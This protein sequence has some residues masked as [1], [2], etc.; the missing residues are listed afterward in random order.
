MRSAG[1]PYCYTSNTGYFPPPVL[2]ATVAVPVT[3]A[4][5]VSVTAAAATTTSASTATATLATSLP[6]ATTTAVAV[7]CGW[8]PVPLY[9]GHAADP[10]TGW[11]WRATNPRCG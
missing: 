7:N 8:N 4:T 2:A 10:S 9:G 1:A 11:G 3:L 5:A 6:F